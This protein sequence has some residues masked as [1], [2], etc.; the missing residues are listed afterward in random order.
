MGLSIAISVTLGG[1]AVG[2]DFKRP[3]PPAEAGS[4]YTP[5]PMPTET[6][7]AET[8]SGTSGVAQRFVPAQEIPAQWWTLFHSEP[9]DR[10][11]HAALENNPNMTAAQAA[12]R[13]AQENYDAQRGGAL[14]PEVTGQLSDTH[15]KAS[16]FTPGLAG[17]VF[18]LYNA[19]VN[20]SYGIDLFGGA[21]RALE[22]LQAAVDYQRYQNEA[23]Y[24]TLT[25]N[26][27]TTAIRE[28]SL[29]A[30][31][32]ATRE[33]MEAQG[34]QSEVIEKQFALGAIPRSTL[35][36][37][38][39]QAA[40]TAAGLPALEKSLAQTRHQLSVLA[41]KLPSEAGMPEFQLDS[42]T[43]PR[44]L[45]LS[46]P[47]E[48]VRQRPDIQASEALLHEAS[49]Q[50]GVATANQYPQFTLNGSY[51]AT[52]TK[53]ADVFSS[54]SSFWSLGAALTQPIFNGGALSAKKRA[55]VA[56]YDQAS[57][58]YRA[59]VLTAFQNVADSLRALEFDAAALKAQADAESIARESLELATK[60]YKLGAVSYLVLLDAQRTYQQ[61]HIG[62]VQ[63][64][65]TRF[66]DTAA[67][68]Q[69]LGGGWWNRRALADA[70]ASTVAAKKD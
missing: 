61:A 1:C 42:L 47:S 35:L 23:T 36:I 52:S 28:A 9:L 10:L 60:Q 13:Q 67:L 38:R 70:T 30:Q 3:E 37:Q 41:G 45:P 21:R 63:A 7:S 44:D 8:A 27:V 16:P 49:A 46:L 58:Q 48:L 56:A 5:I 24:L 4:S 15:E 66:A 43:L 19:S 62:L 64:Q 69:A 11:I 20:V 54:G 22:G 29:R 55:A 6:V 50:V 17:H 57:A 39:N 32:Q 34:K 25:S 65:A 2:P 18:N 31:L 33:V 26:L 51:G 12:L 68:F 59:T 14:Y 40:Q 53:I